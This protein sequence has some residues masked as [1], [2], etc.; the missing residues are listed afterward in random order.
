MLNKTFETLRKNPVILVGYALGV[1]LLAAFIYII[2]PDINELFKIF[3]SFPAS[4]TQEDLE[5][6]YSNAALSRVCLKLFGVGIFAFLGGVTFFAGFG[7]I[8]SIAA[9]GEK[10]SFRNMASGISEFFSVTLLSALLYFAIAMIASVFLSCITMIPLTV[11]ILAVQG[12]PGAT[13]IATQVVNIFNVLT[14]MFVYPFVFMWLPAIYMEDSKRVFSSFAMG[15]RTARQ[16]YLRLLGVSAL[17]TIPQS[18]VTMFFVDAANPFAS[19]VYYGVMAFQAILT[20]FVLVYIFCLYKKT[21]N[22]KML[23]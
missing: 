2:Y 11:V 23:P 4:A 3:S 13:N 12:D 5:A 21:Q 19:P 20:L 6:F 7:A 8:L 10:P 15:M 14:Y 18:V 22:E 1:A 17:I 16:N 9:G